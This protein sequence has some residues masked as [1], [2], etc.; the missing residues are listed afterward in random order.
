MKCANCKNEDL[1]IIEETTDTR[2]KFYKLIGYFISAIFAILA[3]ILFYQAVKTFDQTKIIIAIVMAILAIVATAT[4]KL[5][6]FFKIKTSRTKIVCKNCGMWWY[7]END[8]PNTI[9][10]EED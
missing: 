3:I 9:Y 7:L 8:K 1:Q 6:I 2:T 10:V 4:T 5:I